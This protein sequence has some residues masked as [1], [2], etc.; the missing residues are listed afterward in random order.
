MSPA[1]PRGGRR[2][3]GIAVVGRGTVKV[4]PDLAMFEVSAVATARQAGDAMGQASTSKQ[5]MIDVAR[6]EGVEEADRQTHGMHLSSWRDRET[7][8]V[9]H[10]ARQ[11]LQLRIRSVATAG[12]TLE[13]I[14]AAG[15][16]RAQV[17]HSGLAVADEQ[18]F[19]DRA[20]ELAMAD[21]RRR[22][23]QLSRLAGRPLGDVVAI[24]EDIG[25]DAGGVHLSG[26]GA[27]RAS[28]PAPVELGELE[29][30]CT[31]AVDFD[32]AD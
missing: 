29:V 16:D 31:V 14:L 4:A 24:R 18:P 32:W 26:G 21:A 22:A 23:E 8:P 3:T 7:G 6:S 9:L 17:D 19:A 12:T 20:R 11:R 28:K 10:H 5:A 27:R 1:G 2:F 15:D 25:G 13:R 30:E